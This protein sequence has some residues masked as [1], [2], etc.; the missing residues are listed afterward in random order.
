MSRLA[1][2]GYTQVEGFGGVY[3]DVAGFRQAMDSAG[4]T[5]P[6]GHFALTELETDF[7][8]VDAIATALGVSRIYCPFLL[9][10]DRPTDAAGWSAI[11]KRLTLVGNR[12]RARVTDLVGTIMILNLRP[13][14]MAKS[15]C[16]SCSMP[17]PIWIGRSI[18]HG[19]CAVGL[20]P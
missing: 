13:A 4:L 16:K 3:D 15:R 14:R 8:R 19:S 18:S 2:L 9:P 7:D 17:A 1:E 10:E 20:I 11:A 12:V 5:M 6:S